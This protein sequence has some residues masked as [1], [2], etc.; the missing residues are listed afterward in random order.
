MMRSGCLA[1]SEFDPGQLCS[2]D[3]ACGIED[4]GEQFGALDGGM[5][6]H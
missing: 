2:L 4:G 3:R 5:G 6:A 1:S